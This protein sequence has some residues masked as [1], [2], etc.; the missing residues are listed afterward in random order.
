M[1]ETI[2]AH[3]SGGAQQPWR[4]P[5]AQRPVHRCGAHRR[6]TDRSRR[7][8]YQY[9]DGATFWCYLVA[10]IKVKGSVPFTNAA[11]SASKSWSAEAMQDIRQPDDRHLPG[12]ELAYLDTN[13][14]SDLF[15]TPLK[16]QISLPRTLLSEDKL[17]TIGCDP[18]PDEAVALLIDG[19]NC[20]PDLVALA[21]AEAHKFGVVRLRRVYANW[22]VMNQRGWQMAFQRYALEPVHHERTATGKNATD[23]ALVVDAM[24]ML[25]RKS[26]GSTVSTCLA[27]HPTSTRRSESFQSCPGNQAPLP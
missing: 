2:R 18:L 16:N 11:I 3:A 8:A 9:Q 25:Y 12:S 5:H 13:R 22:T 27:S 26:P 14:Q 20:S 1:D 15:S 7:P 23:I 10:T 21:I 24:D 6:A 17:A 4:I 19:E